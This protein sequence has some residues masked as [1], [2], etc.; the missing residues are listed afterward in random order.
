[1]ASAISHQIS[2]R[3][4]GEECYISQL[5]CCYEAREAY[6]MVLRLID[7]LV[8]NHSGQMFLLRHCSTAIL[9]GAIPAF[10]PSPLS[11]TVSRKGAKLHC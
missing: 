1:M 8:S 6:Y 4:M 10:S 9:E 11:N 3:N 7:F 2:H 5:L